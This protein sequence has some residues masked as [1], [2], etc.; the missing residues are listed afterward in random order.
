[1]VILPFN[2]NN[3]TY[4]NIYKYIHLLQGHVLRVFHYSSTW[5]SR[6]RN[7]CSLASYLV[8]SE[9]HS[10]LT[11][12]FSRGITLITSPPRVLT[13]MLLPT[14]SSTSMD[15]VFL[16]PGGADKE[17]R[18]RLSGGFGAQLCVSWA[19]V[20]WRSI[21]LTWSPTA[22]QWKRTAWTWAPPRGRRRWRCLRAPTWTFSPRRCRSAGCCLDLWCPGPPPRQSHW[23][24]WTD[25]TRVMT[26]H[27]YHEE[28][29]LEGGGAFTGRSECTGCSESLWS[30]WAA[31]CFCPP[32]PSCPPWNDCGLS[33]TAWTG[34]DEAEEAKCRQWRLRDQNDLIMREVKTSLMGSIS[35]YLAA[36]SP[37][38]LQVT[39][40]SLIADGTV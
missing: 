39:L 8:L 2:S 5:C 11:S 4:K 9:I 7:Q 13:R 18:R 26:Q 20:G 22:V 17:R 28:P 1:M 33:Q 21:L 3:S 10:S 19:M 36:V 29:E 24:S 31:Q 40:S 38:Y 6:R 27:R 12:S 16:W 15:S 30:W 14:A 34:P 32:L 23:Q 35:L 37:L 25:K